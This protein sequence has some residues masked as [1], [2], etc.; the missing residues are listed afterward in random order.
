MCICVSACVR[1]SVRVCV[2]V[3]ACACACACVCVCGFECECVHHNKHTL[4]LLSLLIPE[5]YKASV[6]FVWFDLMKWFQNEL[7]FAH[8]S[9]QTCICFPQPTRYKQ[10][11][12]WWTYY[13][14]CV[15]IIMPICRGIYTHLR[16]HARTHTYIDVEADTWHSWYD[17]A[18]RPDIP[19]MS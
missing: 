11:H 14:L 5:G 19:W 16:S 7:Q 2:C 6:A 15:I 10:T 17:C 9:I 12:N 13:H 1:A 4:N 18:S 8:M 3:C